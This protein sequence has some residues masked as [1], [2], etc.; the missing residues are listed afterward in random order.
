[1]AH[2]RKPLPNQA[3][4]YVYCVS[5]EHME[6]V[7]VGYWKSGSS[8]LLKRYKTYYPDPVLTLKKVEDCQAY[9]RQ[10]LLRF[11][12]HIVSGE[13]IAKSQWAGILA[14]IDEAK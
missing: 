10:V 12:E 1:M 14:F 5:S 2:K 7:K 11:K 8:Q 9:E 4:G 6:F 13:L 3:S